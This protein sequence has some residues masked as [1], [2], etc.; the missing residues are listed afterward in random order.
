MR[1]VDL[2]N[3][4]LEADRNQALMARI[5][6]N[7]MTDGEGTKV[8]VSELRQL[9]NRNRMAVD[10]FLNWRRWHLDKTIHFNEQFIAIAN[11]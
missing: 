7:A 10:A 6:I 2:Y 3:H 5:L 9:S 11:S 1:A 8:D 4:V